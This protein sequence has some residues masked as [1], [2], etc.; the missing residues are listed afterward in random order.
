[1][2]KLY[3][4]INALRRPIK[5]AIQFTFG[6]IKSQQKINFPSHIFGHG[7]LIKWG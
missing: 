5:Q 2:H 3:K 7:A 6:A 4:Q 1:M